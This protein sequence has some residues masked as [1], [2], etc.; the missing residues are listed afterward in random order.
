MKGRDDEVVTWGAGETAR[1]GDVGGAGVLTGAET[2]VPTSLLQ[3]E[4]DR[5]RGWGAGETMRWG[6]G[7]AAKRRIGASRGLG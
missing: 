1:R 2:R 6:D 5:K 3:R 7:E 4:K